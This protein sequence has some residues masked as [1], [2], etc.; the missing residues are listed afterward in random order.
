MKNTV[1]CDR[2]KFSMASNYYLYHLASRKIVL[3]P[4]QKGYIFT[5]YIPQ[6]CTS[7]PALGSI[8]SNK[9]PVATK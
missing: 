7:V 4:S 8:Y 5:S 2:M 9:F 6:K 1:G 3:N